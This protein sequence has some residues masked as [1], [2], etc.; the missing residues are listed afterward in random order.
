M[1]R[2]HTPMTVGCVGFERFWLSFCFGFAAKERDKWG[3]GGCFG[4]SK[5]E[6]RATWTDV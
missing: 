5:N 6:R 3:E 1:W 2:D 4:D